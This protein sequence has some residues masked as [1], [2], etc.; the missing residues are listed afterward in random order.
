[1]K[2]KFMGLQ[3]SES[4]RVKRTSSNEGEGSPLGWLWAIAMLEAPFFMAIS[5][6]FLISTFAEVTLPSKSLTEPSGIILNFASRHT[7]S[8]TSCFSEAIFERKNL[9][10]L[11]IVGSIPSETSKSLR[12]ARVMQS[13]KNLIDIAADSP[14]PFVFISSSG[15]VS[16]IPR[17]FLYFF[18]KS[19]AIGFTSIR[20]IKNVSISSTTS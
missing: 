14:M 16:I 11:L 12:A 9:M 7:I 18:I 17:K 3:A 1:M 2:F 4:L 15:G 10:S 20:G 8:R 5:M 6:I 13:L 19:F